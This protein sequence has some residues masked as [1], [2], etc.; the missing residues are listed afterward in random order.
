LEPSAASVKAGSVS[1][2]GPRAAI[3]TGVGGSTLVIL[4]GRPEG[5]PPWRN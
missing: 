3:V 4:S 2:P 5:A 1:L